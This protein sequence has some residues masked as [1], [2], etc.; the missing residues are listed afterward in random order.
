MCTPVHGI[1]IIRHVRKYWLLGNRQTKVP[2]ALPSSFLVDKYIRT[3]PKKLFLCIRW[4]FHDDA[5]IA[6]NMTL[7]VRK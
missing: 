3:A 7:M 2:F 6:L 4:H 1:F 5:D